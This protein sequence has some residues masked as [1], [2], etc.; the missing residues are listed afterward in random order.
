MWLEGIGAECSLPGAQPLPTEADVPVQTPEQGAGGVSP[1]TL[2]APNPP[3]QQ[4]PPSPSPPTATSNG[5]SHVTPDGGPKVDPADTPPSTADGTIPTVPLQQHYLRPLNPLP[6]YAL[7][8]ILASRGIAPTDIEDWLRRIQTNEPAPGE[9][10]PTL[11]QNNRQSPTTVLDPIDPFTGRYLLTV[12]D[13]VIPSPGMDLHLVRVYASG[14]VSFGPFGFNWDHSYNV[15]VRELDAG[16]VAVRTGTLREDV[17]RPGASGQL[18]PP[19]GVFRRLESTPTSNPLY[20]LSDREGIRYEFDRPSHWPL[21]GRIPLVRICDRHANIHTLEYDSDGRVSSVS[22]GLGR[23]IVFEYG[24]CGLLERVSDHT[25]RMWTYVHDE[26]AEHL[27]A[28][29]TPATAEHPE[30]LTTTFEYDADRSH[31][32][33]RHNIVRVINSDGEDVCENVYGSDPTSTDFNRLVFQRVGGFETTLSATELQVVPR[34]AYAVNAP[35]LRVEIVDPGNYYIYTYNFR[36]DLLDQRFR[37]LLDKSGRLVARNFRYDEQANL[38]E[39]WEPNGSAVLRRFDVDATDPRGRGNLLRTELVAA[40]DFVVPSRIVGQITYDASGL[41][42]QKVKNGRGETT[43]FFYDTDTDPNGKGDLIRVEYPDVTLPDGTTQSSTEEF[44]YDSRGLI[45]EHR[46]GEGIR[47]VYEYEATGPDAG[48]LRK[49]VQD[50]DGVA[51]TTTFEYDIWGHRTAQV[52]GLGGRIEQTVNELGLVTSR[53]APASS[54]GFDEVRFSYDGKQLVRREEWPRGEYDDGVIADPFI[55]HEYEY[56][57][58]GH[59]KAATF[60][61]NTGRAT[62][63]SFSADESGRVFKMTDP[64]GHVTIQRFDERGLLID[65]IEAAG[66]PEEARWH[67]VYERIGRRRRVVDPAGQAIDFSYDAW[68]RLMEIKLQGEP[69]PERTRVILQYDDLDQLVGEAVQGLRADGTIGELASLSIHR[70]QRGRAIRRTSA[71]L[72][73]TVTYDRDDRVVRRVDKRGAVARLTYDGLS[74]IVHGLDAAGNAIE[75]DFDAAGR[76][77]AMRSIE[78]QADGTTRTYE[79]SFEY[80]SAGRLWRHTD[81][82]G[83]QT[84]REYDARGLP[85]RVVDR[86]GRS[87]RMSYGLEQQIADVTFL[88]AAGNELAVH[89]YE[90]DLIGR[91]TAYIDPL[92]HT[93]RWRYDARGRQ[94]AVIYADAREHQFAY[95]ALAQPELETLPSGTVLSYQYAS[96]GSLARLDATPGPGLA[97][98]PPLLLKHDGLG[99]VVR[100]EQGSSILER[101]Y[102]QMSRLLFERLDGL[103]SRHEVDDAAGTER[104]I[105]P[106]GRVDVIEHDLL[107]RQVR[108]S[109]VIPGGAGA[110][111]SLAMGA[112]LLRYTYNGSDSPAEREILGALTCRYGYDDGG[113]LVSVEHKAA[114]SELSTTRYVHDAA[115]RRR[116][117]WRSPAPNAPLRAEFDELDHLVGAATAPLPVP[118]SLSSQADANAAIA[119]AVSTPATLDHTYSVDADDSRTG[120]SSA[121]STDTYT[122]DACRRIMTL[123]RA[124]PGAGTWT[125][126]YDSDGRLTR[127]DRHAYS[128]DAMGRLVEVADVT[129][130]TGVVSLEY[131]P[132]GRLVAGTA[133]GQTFHHHHHG[134]RRV[135]TSFPAG[136]VQYTHGASDDELVLASDDTNRAL[137]SDLHETLL[138]VADASGNVVERYDYDVF[139]RATIW[140]GT[141]VTPRTSSSVGLGPRF[142]TYPRLPAE[143]YDARA[144]VYV[145]ALGRFLQPDPL[146]FA[147]SPDRYGYAAANPIDLYDPSGEIGILVGIAIAAGIGLVAGLLTNGVRQAIAISEGAQDDFEWRQFLLSGGMGAVGGALLV[148]APEL[149]LPLAAMGAYGGYQEY[150]AGNTATGIFDIAVSVAPFGFKGV[151]KATFGPGTWG[152]GPGNGIRARADRFRQL[153]AAGGE[154][155]LPGV[156]VRQV[157]V[158]REG[159]TVTAWEKSVATRYPVIREWAQSTIEAQQRGL[160]QLRKGG[161]DSADILQPYEPDGALVIEHAGEPSAAAMANNSSLRPAFNEY[162]RAAAPVAAG[163]I[164]QLPLVGP[165]IARLRIG[166][167]DL[168]DRNI[169]Y[170]PGRGFVAFDPSVEGMYA[171]LGST[172]TFYRLGAIPLSGLRLFDDQPSPQHASAGSPK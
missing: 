167:H 95:G 35:T 66:T 52:D 7:R 43:T 157:D 84:T 25:G 27:V 33:L 153:P 129:T 36:G 169:G 116:I 13:V 131:D 5:T 138:A 96:D 37:L 14:H 166:M 92:G 9:P 77:A 50:A 54:G 49:V 136:I 103:E 38:S 80:D 121:G 172:W 69:E 26:A 133:A 109:L 171:G 108:R 147:G 45:V 148:V 98:V 63:Y 126:D 122:L 32:A 101:D 130:G 114:G 90:T 132:A 41:R 89:R 10:H 17:F 137:L 31:P 88:G 113:R 81:A 144:R 155:R 162:Y 86:L 159:E 57:V 15:Y 8:D 68:G 59:I 118:D 78:P 128:Y 152:R 102:D 70:D 40:P 105:F 62:R 161:I 19:I 85:V 56:D 72:E 104:F 94:T 97:P 75:R 141:G 6:D 58:L 3:P 110:T 139:G 100:L 29:M 21:S 16:A 82:L 150:Q 28:A 48:Y 60:G 170:T 156:R 163:R 20:I 18:E 76:L 151:R 107:G 30:G 134:D 79:S 99:R 87:T 154:R 73:L 1:E 39:R 165:R 160:Q 120:T 34:E 44:D 119:S 106:D 64:L 71:G 168:A 140:D 55:A 42:V 11:S 51:D 123:Q 24:T 91:L 135:Q 149:A 115:D 74:R 61:V 47:H 67:S 83:R 111:G 164:G 125:F 124:G 142:A 117:V 145:P 46:T 65:R 112:E 12:S 2:G 22:D 158:R 127:D 4:N 143:L 23:A 53:R 146:L 93:T